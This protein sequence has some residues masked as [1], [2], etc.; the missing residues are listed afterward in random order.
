[1]PV[2]TN[3]GSAKSS[4]FTLVELLVVIAII[5]IL[6]GLLLP[7]VQAA[8]EAARRMSCSNNMKQIGLALH[9]YAATYKR[10]PAR[11]GGTRHGPR[12]CKN[13]GR[14][15]GH[16]ALLAFA[17]Q[18]AMYNQIQAGDP[19][20]TNWCST[21][22]PPGGPAAW[23]NWVVWRP[24]PAY[25]RCPSDPGPRPGQREISYGMSVGDSIF[26]VRGDQ[27]QIRGLFANR[28]FRSFADITDGTSNTVAFSEL[29]NSRPFPAGGRNGATAEAQTVPHNKVYVRNVSGIHKNPSLC[30]SRT[31]GRFVLGGEIFAGRRGRNWT[32]G[33]PAY[34]AISTVLPPNGPACAGPAGNFGDQR[35]MV[36]PPASQ[37]TGG[38]NVALADGSV[39]FITE[40]I[41]T[42]NL[43]AG[44]SGNRLRGPSPY[45][46]WGALGTIGATD[47]STLD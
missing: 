33:Q 1:M 36:L 38:V 11:K 14:L 43:S 23:R 15:S 3:F 39:R 13:H 20:H 45:G 37:H 29:L 19:S 31:D 44:P 32:D 42:G 10:F 9:S 40:N 2:R 12:H 28:I 34:V 4:G 16:I 47:V 24:A 30:Y 27:H 22:I 26:R 6:V 5:G 21:G 41:D 46:V 7:A 17:E 8:R 25:L 18:T 35:D